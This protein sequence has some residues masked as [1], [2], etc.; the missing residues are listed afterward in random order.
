MGAPFGLRGAFT[1]T[2]AEEV[3]ADGP[4]TDQ[5]MPTVIRLGG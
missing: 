2:A 5:V 1:M 3:C 4:D